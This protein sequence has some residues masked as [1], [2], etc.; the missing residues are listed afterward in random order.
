[1]SN[2]NNRTNKKSAP[3][4]PREIDTA[5]HDSL[6]RIKNRWVLISR[7]KIATW[8]GLLIIL[9]ISGFVSALFWAGYRNLYTGIFGEPGEQIINQAQVTY[10]DSLGAEYG[11]LTATVSV[12]KSDSPQRVSKVTIKFP[13]D[14]KADKVK[15]QIKDEI[16]QAVLKEVS[17]VLDSNYELALPV[18]LLT[19]DYIIMMV[20]PRHLSKK[21]NISLNQS[22][23][24]LTV[25]EADLASGNL[26]DTDDMINAADWD[27]MRGKW[28]SI[29]D[30]EADL[31]Q[32]GLVN[33]LDW[34]IMKK[35]WGVKGDC[36]DDKVAECRNRK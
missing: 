21:L 16:S 35:N 32:D 15:I 17:A 14:F 8:Q 5:I 9:F 28:G 24:L 30:P 20:P 7:H 1:M 31:N 10:Q 36:P 25:I 34:S 23:V 2:H 27:I 13:K 12:T 19:G 33:T 3:N 22:E 26:F 6:T 4:L 18:D 11:P 29:I